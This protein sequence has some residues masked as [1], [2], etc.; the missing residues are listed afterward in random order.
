MDLITL[1]NK[2]DIEFKIQT[3]EENLN[4]KIGSKARI[5]AGNGGGTCRVFSCLRR[6]KTC[7]YA[8]CRL[9]LAHH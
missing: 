6:T 7:F 9:R 5:P 4:E 8:A 1:A 3:N 2:L